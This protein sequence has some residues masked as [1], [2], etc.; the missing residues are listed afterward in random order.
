MRQDGIEIAAF[1]RE[2]SPSIF[3]INCRHAV[4]RLQQIAQN[5]WR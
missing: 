5:N 2:D 3:Q 4:W 1:R